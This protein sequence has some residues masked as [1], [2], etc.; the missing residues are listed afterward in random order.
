[1]CDKAMYECRTQLFHK[2]INIVACPPIINSSKSLLKS[3]KLQHNPTHNHIP[4][5]NGQIVK[6]NHFVYLGY[7]STV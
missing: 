5:I 3:N 7:D 1:M 2:I 4:T 6:R